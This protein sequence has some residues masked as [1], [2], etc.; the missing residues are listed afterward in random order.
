MSQ[1]D[2]DDPDNGP[3]WAPLRFAVVGPLLAAPPA[4]GELGPELRRLS[5]KLWR[6]PATAEPVQ[7]GFS[8]VERWY[9]EAKNQPTDPVGV[10]HNKVRRDRGSCKLSEAFKQALAVQW[11][12]YKNFSY[13][14][15][16]DNL[17]VLVKNNPSLGP[18]PHYS[19]VRRYMQRTGLVRQRQRG[20]KG[21]PGGQAAMERF[22]KREVR[23]YQVEYVHALWHLDFHQSSRAVVTPQGV[24]KKPQ[25]LAVLDDCSRLCC[26]AQWYWEEEEETL[27]HGLCQAVQ[28]RGLPRALMSDQGGAMRAAEFS[29]GLLRLGILHQPTLGY[30]PE[31]NGKQEYFWTQIE[32]RLLPMLQGT[33]EL[34]LGRLNEVTQ[35][36]VEM[37][38]NRRLHSAIGNT[39]LCRALDGPQ[40]GR[41]S[42]SAE[43]LRQAFTQSVVRTQRKSDGTVTVQGVRYE[44]PSRYRTLRRVYV[45]YARW[46]LSWILLWDPRSTQVLCKLLPQD[47]VKNAEGLRA[48]REPLPEEAPEIPDSTPP[49]PA[50]APLLAQCLAD[51]L[52]TGAPPAYLPKDELCEPNSPSDPEK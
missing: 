18:M 35:A 33:Q 30:S 15:H 28:K 48:L 52:A 51:Y 36:Y 50:L 45:R 2:M 25:L 29:A 49:A 38:Y 7:F 42:P 12:H 43:P 9:Y 23:S 10:L 41:S 26:H 21:S 14:L 4:H 34:T 6:H 32:G 46:D 17:K 40:V 24:Y 1:H 37:E 44:V 19:T 47:K 3:G 16:T 5:R 8:T 13:Q 11:N 22:E 20:P 27:I 39:P 31:Q